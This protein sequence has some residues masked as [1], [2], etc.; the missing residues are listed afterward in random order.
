MLAIGFIDD[1]NK[2][3]QN[4]KTRLY[5]EGIELFFVEDCNDM[6][7]VVEWI[8]NNHIQCMLVDYK[9]TEKYSYKG[10]ELVALINKEM[11]DLPCIMLTNNPLDG[12]NENLVVKNL[13]ID[14]EIMSHDAKDEKY[15]DFINTLKQATEV[16]TTRMELNLEEFKALKIKKDAMSITALEEEDYIK[17]YKVLRAYNV[18]DDLPVELLTSSGSQQ[19]TQILESLNTMIGKME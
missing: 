15:L 11:P 7:S 5:R 4:Y 3:L 18:V 10:T 8:G 12:I 9:L 19:M 13:F 6:K 17:L 1:E 14:R 2:D 16:F